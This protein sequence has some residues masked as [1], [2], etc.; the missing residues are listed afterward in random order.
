MCPA[1][2]TGAALVAGSVTTTGGLSV[3]LLKIF[4]LRKE[5]KNQLRGSATL[6][7]RK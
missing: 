1:C 6:Q 2:L 5:H 4:R 7:E 3:L